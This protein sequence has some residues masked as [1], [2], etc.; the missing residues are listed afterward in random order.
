ME[1]KKEDRRVR[2]TKLAIRDSLVELM[3]L[4]PISKVSVKMLCETADVNRSTF[5]A[6]YAD[7]Y[8][9]LRQ[10]QAEAVA[11]I[12]HHL[13]NKDLSQRAEITV[14]ALTEILQYA[15]DNRDLFRVLLSDNGD[16][17]FRQEVVFLAQ[18]RTIEK[19]RADEHIDLRMAAYLE[20]FAVSG[21]I[22]VIGGWL[23]EG[24]PDE[25]AAL[26]ELITKLLFQGVSWYYR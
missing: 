10:I 20:G 15:R 19:I 1:Y 22:S 3:R 5:Y 8:D 21:C 9:L 24:C 6:H 25:P 18:Q 4:H 12:K 7:Q 11:D 13:T 16:A 17:S 26:A 23:D 2:I 14:P